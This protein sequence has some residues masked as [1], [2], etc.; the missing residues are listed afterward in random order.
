MGD[1]LPLAASSLLAMTS[2]TSGEGR[3]FSIRP[4]SGLSLLALAMSQDGWRLDSARSWSVCDARDGVNEHV[5]LLGGV[6][7]AH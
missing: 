6:R 1:E 7:A 3:S 5:W 4:T 2:I